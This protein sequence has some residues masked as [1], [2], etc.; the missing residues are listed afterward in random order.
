MKR[1]RSRS[2]RKI[3][4]G[5]GGAEGW[6]E[7]RAELVGTRLR[8]MRRGYLRQPLSFG[9]ASVRVGFC[10]RPRKMYLSPFPGSFPGSP[11][12]G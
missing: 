11:F 9:I 6:G 8:G 12:P 10:G 5:R 3:M 2:K 7:V 1:I 4:T